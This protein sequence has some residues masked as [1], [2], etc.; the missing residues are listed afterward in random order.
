MK[1]SLKKI[2]L[3]GLVLTVASA[4][5]A[6]MTPA[7]AK[8]T[9]GKDGFYFQN[10]ATDV[11]ST[12]TFGNGGG[13]DCHYTATGQGTTGTTVGNDDPTGTTAGDEA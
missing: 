4:V 6:A 11:I 3:L 2:S 12:C 9:V 8:P 7:K 13:V 5:T 1:L 10:Q